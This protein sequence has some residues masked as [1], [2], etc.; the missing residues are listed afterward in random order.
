MLRSLL[1]KAHP[2]FFS[3]PLLGPIADGFDDWLAASGYT[4][5]SREFAIRML[6]HVDADLR[7]R[8]PDAAS[9][10]H[11]TLHACWRD[12]IK[13][14]PTNAGTVRALERYL[15]VAGVIAAERSEAAGATVLRL[16]REYV[17]HLRDV[18]GFAASTVSSHRRTAECFLQHLDEGGTAV[19]CIRPSHIESYIAKAGRRLSRATLQHE[20]AALR[21]FLRYLSTDGRAPASLDRQIDTPRLYRLE[22]LPRALSWETLHPS[23]IH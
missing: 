11:A 8:I 6:P 3:L 22:Q 23:T 4:P 18:R 1:P 19:G 7:R 2:K 9:L 5:G 17:D 20:I 15:T 21:G 16:S 14:F 10:T 12:L 13:D